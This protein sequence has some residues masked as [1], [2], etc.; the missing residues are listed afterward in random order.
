MLRQKGFTSFFGS[1][2]YQQLVPENH[3]LRK[4]DELITWMPVIQKITPCYKGEFTLGASALNPI[5]P[6]KMMFLGYLY[7][8][9]DR[10]LERMCNDTISFK[11]FIEI[12]IDEAAPDHS[13]LSLFRKRIIEYYEDESA[14]EEIFLELLEQIIAA[15]IQLG[16]VQAIDSKHL[17]ARVSQHR[18]TKKGKEQ[19]AK[20]KEKN[21]KRKE[22][23][24]KEKDYRSKQDI[25]KEASVGCKG[26]EKKKD[27]NG[28][29]VEMPKWFF[30][31]K[32]HCSVESNHDLVTS[33]IL[34][35]GNEDDGSFFEPLFMK[36]I[37]V[38]HS[39]PKGY[40]ADKGY[41]YGDSHFLLNQLGINNGIYLKEARLKNDALHA[42]WHTLNNSEEHKKTKKHR[43]KVERTFGDL[44]NNHKLKDCFSFGRIKAA[45]QMFMSAIVHNLKKAVKEIYGVSHKTPTNLVFRT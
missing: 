43:F 42:L 10:D 16:D 21:Q 26:I 14:F 28:K 37:A 39:I 34:T 6:F 33:A 24:K 15:G 2:M 45:I 4:T 3:F 8:L 36:D 41:D 1:Q 31:Y 9:S 5:I 35:P 32:A 40:T 22:E 23:G 13:T 25:D 44:H 27:K 17:N 19:K 7:N 20:E 12:G 38:R 18:Q 11:Y 30:G 29:I